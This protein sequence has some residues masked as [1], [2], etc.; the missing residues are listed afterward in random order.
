MSDDSPCIKGRLGDDASQLIG[1]LLVAGIQLAAMSR[2]DQPEHERVPA[3]L[4]AD[5]F[6]NFVASDTFPTLLAEMR[7]Y[8]LG[9]TCAHQYLEQLDEATAAAV[10]GNVGTTISFRVGK[11]A[12]TIAEQF[13]GELT[14]EDLRNLPKHHAY[15]RLLI[16][17]LP[18]KVFS[19]TTLPPTRLNRPRGSVV[20][21]VSRER[22]GSPN[23][24]YSSPAAALP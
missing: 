18:S 1:S 24:L 4:F 22:F 20:R 21:R 17:G 6:Q 2:A 8:R 14:P 10:W 3:M 16:D 7:K 9:L 15:V 12:D 5:E 11:D 23:T 13:G 19:M